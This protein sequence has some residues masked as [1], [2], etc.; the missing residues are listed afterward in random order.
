MQ[1]LIG[2]KVY[3]S[4]AMT[5]ASE[6]MACAHCGHPITGERKIKRTKAGEKQ[7][8]Y[9]RCARYTKPGHPRVRV[10]EAEID[11][12]ILA[13]FDRM[14]IEDDEVREW[15]RAVLASQTK[16]TLLTAVE[17]GGA[18]RSRGG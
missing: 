4:H 17:N 7:Y 8:V 18:G 10:R 1:S 12:Q 11:R 13:I 6:F 2:G 15:F 14:R 9:Y 3:Q 16:D 5:Y